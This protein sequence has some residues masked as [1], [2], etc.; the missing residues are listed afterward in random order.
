MM[1]VGVGAVWVTEWE[2]KLFKMAV[3]EQRKNE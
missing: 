1:T 2:E 3:V